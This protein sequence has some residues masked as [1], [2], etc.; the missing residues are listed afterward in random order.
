M[1]SLMK[2]LKHLF[3]PILDWPW[4][5]STSETEFYPDT[6]GIHCEYLLL[7][8]FFSPIHLS[9]FSNWIFL[10]EK[11]CQLGSGNDLDS[12]ELTSPFRVF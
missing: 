9:S 1:C 10:I 8:F 6:V 7:Q 12:W 11:K 5:K 4:I 2:K 3:V